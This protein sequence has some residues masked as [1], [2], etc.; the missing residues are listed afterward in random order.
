M[1]TSAVPFVPSLE[2]DTGCCHEKTGVNWITAMERSRLRASLADGVCALS[3]CAG[4]RYV[5][6]LPLSQVRVFNTH[7]LSAV[8]CVS[9]SHV[10]MCGVDSV[11]RLGNYGSN[12]AGRPAV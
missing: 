9:T 8:G 6:H 3:G 10:K 11:T 2:S 12:A 7:G 1:V 5:E 4:C